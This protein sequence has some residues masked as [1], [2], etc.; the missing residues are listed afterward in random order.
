MPNT[1][2]W[3]AKKLGGGAPPPRPSPGV[4]PQQP[5]APAYQ[6]APAPQQPVDPNTVKPGDPGSLSH[7]LATGQ[8]KGGAAAKAN[9]T[10]TCPE[11]GSGNYIFMRNMKT[12]RCYDCG[13]PVVQEFS[14]GGVGTA[15]LTT[16][17]LG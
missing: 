15:A 5:A 6:Q 4:P 8:T 12:H 10:G 2:D 3:F 9:A 7:A 14:E 17:G 1:A 11:C 16:R 13:Y